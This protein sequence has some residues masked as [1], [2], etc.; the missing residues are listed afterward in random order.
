MPT[1]AEQKCPCCGGGV[2]FDAGAQKLKCPYCETEFEINQLNQ[3]TVEE[4]DS[5][6]WS[7]QDNQWSSGETDGM[8]V[9]SCQSCG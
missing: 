6:N 9:Y 4:A 8:N 3:E 1:I 2:Q 7:A 5:I